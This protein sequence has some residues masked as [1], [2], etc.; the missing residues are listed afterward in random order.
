MTRQGMDKNLDKMNVVI[1]G[2]SEGEAWLYATARRSA[3]GAALHGVYADAAE[4]RAARAA[5]WQCRAYDDFQSVLDDKS[6]HAVF[7]LHPMGGRAEAALTALDAGKRV[8]MGAPFAE[9]VEQAEQLGNASKKHPGML[10][11]A[12]PWFHYPPMQKVFRLIKKRSVGRVMAV[13]MRAVT[14]GRGGWDEYLNPE[15]SPT[16]EPAAPRDISALLFREIYEKISLAMSVF[17]PVA[18]I[19]HYGP[20]AAAPPCAS[21]ITWK[22][23]AS[24]TYG[25]L[26]VV[27]APDMS[28]RSATFPRDDSMEFTG[29]AGMI[30][31]TRGSA[32][33]RNEPTVR[34]FRGENQFTYGN[35]DDDWRAALMHTVHHAMDCLARGAA[36]EPGIAHAIQA[37][38]CAAAAIRSAETS[39]RIS[40]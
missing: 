3:P 24:A 22:H 26:D 20:A 40:L 14:A 2:G 32:Q 16:G 12:E 25:C 28:I 9:T 17:G 6:A 15:F 11:A 34:V 8:I 27:S 4:C 30:W 19:F 37:V 29:S 38:N 21:V 33:L 35:L 31:L 23:A 13:R 7:L 18:E 1:C 39:Q 36:P 5:S 10:A